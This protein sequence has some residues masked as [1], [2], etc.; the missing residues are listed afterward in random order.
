MLRALRALPWWLSV[1]LA[2]LA[3]S[4]LALS[5]FVGAHD[6]YCDIDL[7][8]AALCE[9]ADGTLWRGHSGCEAHN[10]PNCRPGQPCDI[11]P[12]RVVPEPAKASCGWVYRTD[13]PAIG[14]PPYE[15]AE[16]P[17]S[18]GRYVDS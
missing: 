6:V 4:G 13:F 2:V 15:Y 11:A 16:P 14:D 1:P 5:G 17:L 3:L 9:R 12:S 18:G 8:R 10:D 7:S